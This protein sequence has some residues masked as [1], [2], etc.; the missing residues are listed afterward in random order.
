[1][2]KVAY[3]QGVWQALAD[4]GITKEASPDFAGSKAFEDA[5]IV[6]K[7]AIPPKIAQALEWLSSQGGKT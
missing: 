2:N 6:K 5:G 4:T 1:M 3:E 7:A